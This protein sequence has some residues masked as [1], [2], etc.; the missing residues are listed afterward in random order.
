MI[1]LTEHTFEVH[2][3]RD[4]RLDGA[5]P[6]AGSVTEIINLGVPKQALITWASNVTA[7]AAVDEW[8]R[9]TE[10]KPSE[11]LTYLKGARSRSSDPAKLR[12]TQL[13]TLLEAIIL[14]RDTPVPDDL[15]DA[16][17]ALQ[18]V[19]DAWQL[20]P[21]ATETPVANFTYGYAG[22]FDLIADD[23]TGRHIIDLKSGRDIYSDAAL[24]LAGYRYAEA[25]LTPTGTLTTMLA[26]D[27]ARV[28]HV[29]TD[30]AR[31][32]PVDAGPKTW[33]TFLH[34]AETAKWVKAEKAAWTERRA[35][36]IGRELTPPQPLTVIEGGA[37]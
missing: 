36:P 17:R 35:W 19:V 22:R 23:P 13:H 30:S 26:V 37:A 7:E 15:Y 34:A 24:Q 20:Q 25:A 16:A 12:G 6:R 2:G 21:I 11:R 28:I 27:G 8:D 29:T 5:P 14:G 18:R 1:D 4:Y 31:I 32:V 3:E 9:L 33:R 10:L